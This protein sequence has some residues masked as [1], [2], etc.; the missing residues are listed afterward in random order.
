MTKQTLE[1]KF[2]ESLNDPKEKKMIS[3]VRE[4]IA[5]STFI[6]DMKAVLNDYATLANH[7]SSYPEGRDEAIENLRG[8]C[9]FI[10]KYGTK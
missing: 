7:Y 2:E 9:A 8:L 3:V 10:E 5:K 1:E 6:S 4:G